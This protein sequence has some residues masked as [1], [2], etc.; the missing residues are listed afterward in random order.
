MAK[1]KK[2]EEVNFIMSQKEKEI[3]KTIAE[4]LPKMDDFTKGYL[5]GQ[6]EAMARQKAKENEEPEAKAG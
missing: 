5:L 1:N 3:A 6:V 4:A 2:P